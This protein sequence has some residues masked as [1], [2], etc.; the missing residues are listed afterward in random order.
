M[1]WE[2]IILLFLIVVD[3][4]VAVIVAVVD[5][6]EFSSVDVVIFIL[7]GHNQWK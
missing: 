5:I 4:S 1:E 2:V 3:K 6:V 7:G